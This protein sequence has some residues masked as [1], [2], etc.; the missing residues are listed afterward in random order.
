M[1]DTRYRQT[2]LLVHR[3]HAAEAGRRNRGAVVGIDATDDRVTSGLTHQVPVG[4][5]HAHDRVV[6]LG[7]RAR[8]KHAV[9]LRLADVLEHGRQL[10]RGRV[11][12]LEKV[13]VVRQL[14]H[15]L[16]RSIDEFLPSIAGVH[17][18]KSRHAVKN[19]AAVSVIDVHALGACDDARSLRVQVLVIGERM[20]M[21]FFIQLLPVFARTFFNSSHYEFT[22][23]L[24]MRISRSQGVMISWNSWY[25]ASL[26]A[27]Y[28]STN[29][30]P[31]MS[32]IAFEWRS[33]SIA[34]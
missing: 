1:N 28:R 20:Q 21:V 26:S 22:Y 27:A 30:S 8:E 17:T 11:R 19:P 23:T 3:F 16:R 18:P 6:R 33:A 15:L 13:I 12:A 25:S 32:R 2:A 4:T 9:E 24:N 34:E 31:S 10:D 14:T 29:E 7:T 5:H